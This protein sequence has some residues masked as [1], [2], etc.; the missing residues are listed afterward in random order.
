VIQV[1]RLIPRL[2]KRVPLAEISARERDGV[3]TVS[4]RGELDVASV[5]ALQV[6][7]SEIRWPEQASCVV[8]LTGLA[9]I[10]CACL[11]VLTRQ[12]EQMQA[13]GGS[14]ALAGPHGSVLRLLS[15]TGLLTW[16][17]VP[18]GRETTAPCR[19]PTSS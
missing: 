12:R 6:Y 11:G 4:L 7:L 13:R 9:F 19:A 15:L 2:R 10:D 18:G 1:T 8:D 3:I 17:D 5:P 16:F 14:F